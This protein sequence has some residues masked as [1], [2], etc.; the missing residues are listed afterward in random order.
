MRCT[1]LALLALLA[2]SNGVTLEK[3]KN[4]QKNDDA[5]DSESPAKKHKD[6]DDDDSQ[7]HK[8]S[9]DDDSQ[10]KHKSSDDESAPQDNKGKGMWGESWQVDKETGKVKVALKKGKNKDKKLMSEW[11]DA[12][13]SKKAGGVTSWASLEAEGKHFLVGSKEDKNGNELPA[14]G[15]KLIV[16]HASDFEESDDKVTMTLTPIEP[17]E[18]KSD[19]GDSDSDNGDSDLER[20]RYPWGPYWGVF[21]YPWMWPGFVSDSTSDLE[22]AEGSL[23]ADAIS[24]EAH[25]EKALEREERSN[26]TSGALEKE[27]FPPWGI[28]PHGLYWGAAWW[29]P[30]WW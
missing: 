21:P 15:D 5:D 25:L 11:Y 30:G 26:H 24:L 22:A 19:D 7:K 2:L 14:K 28:Y 8:G 6:S 13:D 29:Y 27:K 18:K 10:K 4:K 9:D 23:L 1:L 20:E 17:E 3:H 12:T 16:L